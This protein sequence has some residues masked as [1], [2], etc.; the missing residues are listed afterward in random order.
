[1]IALVI[2]AFGMGLSLWVLSIPLA[3]ILLHRH[4]PHFF[5]SHLEELLIFLLIPFVV[6]INPLDLAFL[7]E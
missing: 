2:I 3:G 7:A 4:R 5:F 6:S 1:M